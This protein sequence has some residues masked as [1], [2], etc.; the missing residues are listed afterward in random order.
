MRLIWASAAL[1]LWTVQVQA[2]EKVE[3]LLQA[4][5]LDEFIE[6]LQD[7]GGTMGQTLQESFLDN[8]G[9][10]VFQE[11]VARIYDADRMRNQVAE[12]FDQTLSETDL[13]RAILFFES[14]LGQTIV[15]LELTARIALAD[16]TIEDMAEEA[17]LNSDRDSELYRL[18]EEYIEV[19]NLIDE[20]VQNTISADYNFFRGMNLDASV[21][22]TE[23]LAQLLTQKDSMTEETRTWLYSF[24]LLAY[25]PLTDAQMRENIAFSRTTTGRA[26]NDALFESFDWMFDTIYFQLGEAVAQVLKGSDL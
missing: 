25:Q 16:E 14:D 19:N 10:P 6:I 8:M 4:L 9:G 17:Y 1:F 15:S 12:V 22:D 11:Q 21:D 18:V 5:Q 2:E 26:V 13:D 7:E 23:L 20:N 24:F 3:R